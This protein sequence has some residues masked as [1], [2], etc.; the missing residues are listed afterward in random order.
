[1]ANDG[2]RHTEVGKPVC[3]GESSGA[4]GAEAPQEPARAGGSLL[5]RSGATGVM[6]G[7][8]LMCHT[9]NGMRNYNMTA[10]ARLALTVNLDIE[11]CSRYKGV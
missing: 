9:E 11:K 8:N 3:E 1:M 4:G 7:K 6:R 10:I 2:D 5:Y